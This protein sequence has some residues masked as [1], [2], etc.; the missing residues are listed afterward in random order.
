MVLRSS[1]H[2][3]LKDRLRAAFLTIDVDPYAS[4]TFDEFGLERFAPVTYEHYASEE[5]ALRE[6]ERALGV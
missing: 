1:L 6:C 5:R 3:E 2:P 4:A